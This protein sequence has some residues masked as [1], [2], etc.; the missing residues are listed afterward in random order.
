MLPQAFLT[1]M[2]KQLGE[3][4]PAYLSAMEQPPVRG[5]RCT[6]GEAG[7]R[8]RVARLLSLPLEPI[9]YT[10]DG[11]YLAAADKLGRHPL[12]HA[13]AIY[14]QEPGAMFPAGCLPFSPGEKVLDLC[15]S[16]GGK[17]LQAAAAIG[18]EGLL[19]SNEI[20]PARCRVLA[21]NLERMGLA[22]TLVTC[23]SPRRLADAWP[24]AF[25]KV[26]VDA[27]C[28]GEGMFR[29][30]PQ[31]VEQWS[32]AL[33]ESCA[34]LQ[35]EILA[36]AGELVRPGGMLL[37]ATCTFSPQ[38]DQEMVQWFLDSQE[39]MFS[40]CP[41][42]SA[43]G[44]YTRSDRPGMAWF[45]PHSGKGEGQ[46]AAL[47]RKGGEESVR[48]YPLTP[49]PLEGEQEGEVRTFLE[50]A[51]GKAPQAI[52]FPGGTKEERTVV[53][54]PPACLDPKG[55]KLLNW[56]VPVGAFQQSALKGKGKSPRKEGRG[57]KSSRFVPSHWF[58]K[59]YGSK[60]QNQLCL[61]LGDPLVEAYLRGEELP[62]PGLKEGYAA[63][64]VEGYPLGGGKVSAGRLKNY[65]PKGL[66]NF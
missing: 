37:Y 2:E 19:V 58:F 55:V 42:P 18:P 28:S 3:E 34:K 40:L 15:A 48:E 52:L 24:E 26:I 62:V 27:P 29:K 63:V 30:D 35:R 36:A 20:Q 53:L 32:P 38:E 41:L 8:E 31:A 44:P 64:L 43:I 10:D 16:P 33:V 61:S 54:P 7:E 47:F 59:A 57:G 12:H 6:A 21:G 65:Y 23:D 1:R 66:R 60:F 5:L 17:S 14:L 46:F 4:F 45:Y 11:Y 39:G 50:E 49:V 13:G 9:P 25:D 51:L 22:N 56:G